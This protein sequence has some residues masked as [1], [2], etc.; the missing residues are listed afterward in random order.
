MTVLVAYAS[1]HGST[2]EIAEAIV[3]ELRGRGLDVDLRA[4]DDLDDADALDAYD[5][6]V[7]GSAVYFDRW[8]ADAIEVLKRFERELAARPTWLFSA[9]PTGGDPDATAKVIGLLAHPSPLPPGDAGRRAEKLR[10]RGH[11]L[12]GGRVEEAEMRGLLERWMPRGDW[13]DFE[14]IR[15]W[16]DAIAAELASPSPPA[17]P[18]E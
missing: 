4:A 8:Q 9:G 14:A 10:I 16:A 12:F 1:K 5:A 6:V 11:M 2:E 13:R 17:T 3:R 18:V 7:L 15:R